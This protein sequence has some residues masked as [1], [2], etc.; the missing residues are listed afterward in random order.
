MKKTTLLITY[1]VAVILLWTCAALTGC[2]SSSKAGRQFDKDL[3][4]AAAYC[5]ARFPVRDSLIAGDT[6][7][8]PGKNPDISQLVDSIRKTVKPIYIDNSKSCIEAIEDVNAQRKVQ[9]Q[10][11]AEQ[12]G[13]LSRLQRL[14]NERRPDTILIRDTIIRENT[15]KVKD[16]EYRLISITVAADKFRS[17]RNSWRKACLITWG[18]LLAIGAG[19]FLKRKYL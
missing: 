16:L 8:I 9:E 10:R 11:I 18:L 12:A 19:Y 13:Q 5:A 1:L 14:L 6:V 15:A 17:S 7:F 4:A 2:M 3:P